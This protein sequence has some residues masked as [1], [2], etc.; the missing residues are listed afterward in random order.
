MADN[1]NDI[2]R[3]LDEGIRNGDFSAV[4]DAIVETTAGAIREAGSIVADS[5]RSASTEAM[6]EFH[7]TSSGQRLYTNRSET[8]A[9]AEMLQRRRQEHNEQVRKAALEAQERAAQRQRENIERAN[10][11]RKSNR[12]RPTNILPPGLSSK[13]TS[14]GTASIV[15]GITG[16]VISVYFLLYG[17]INMIIGLHGFGPVI[18]AIVFCGIFGYLAGRGFSERHLADRARRYVKICGEKMYSQV[19]AL[20]SAMGYKPSKVKK[21]IRKMLRKGYF[22][23]GY[24]DDEETTL[25]LTDEIYKEYQ[26]TKNY[27]VTATEAIN[28]A[29]VAKEEEVNL[30]DTEAVKNLSE[31]Q[32][33]ELLVMLKD[34]RNYIE[35]L[36]NLNQDIPGEAITKKLYDLEALLTEIFMRITEHPEQMGRMHKLM[37]YYLPTMIKLVEAYADYDKVSSP[38]EEIINAKKDIE[39]TLDTIN[40]AF[41]Q[42]LNNLFQDSIW[43]VTSDAQVL[44]AMLKQE[45]LASDIK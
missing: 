24:L 6:K 19:A 25:M 43:D 18:A 10:A 36:H 16:A 29:K 40:E 41:V 32:K 23:Q 44:T 13:I 37:D 21:D 39:N 26:R 20:A 12:Q 38:G 14:A 34:G 3:K 7:K 8:Q 22:P 35:R 28:N 9:Y 5:I 4:R 1:Y 30:P 27:S 33:A 17:L 42:L 45:G 15:I 11:R 2:E 31:E